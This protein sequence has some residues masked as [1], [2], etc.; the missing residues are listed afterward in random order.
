MITLSLLSAQLSLMDNKRMRCLV[1]MRSRLQTH[2][3][4]VILIQML[5]SCIC[6]LLLIFS[7]FLLIFSGRFRHIIH[8]IQSNIRLRSYSSSKRYIYAMIVLIKEVSL[9]FVYILF[10][11]ICHRPISDPGQSKIRL[12]HSEIRVWTSPILNYGESFH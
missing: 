6:I 1:S 10:C 2:F 9:I 5:F 8:I 4:V 3:M 12:G 7:A 11:Y